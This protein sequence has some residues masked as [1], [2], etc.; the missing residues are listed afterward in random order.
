MSFPPP[1]IFKAYDIRGVVG[2]GRL[3]LEDDER[4]DDV[5]PS[6][7][8]RRE[9]AREDLQRLGRDALLAHLD[10]AGAGVVVEL[11]ER[12]REEPLDP[13][14]LARG[15]HVGCTDLA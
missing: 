7:D 9:L 15:R 6:L 12:L 13:E 10:A 4:R 3:L 14:L 5:H 1:E 11:V 2:V 8:H